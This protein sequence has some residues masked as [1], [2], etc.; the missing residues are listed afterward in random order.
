MHGCQKDVIALGT[1]IL[2]VWTPYLTEYIESYSTVVIFQGRNIVVEY[3]QFCVGIN[4]IAIHIKQHNK[5]PLAR[6]NEKKMETIM[7]LTF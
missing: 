5:V 4:L 6:Q 7:L 2:N 3:G 1:S